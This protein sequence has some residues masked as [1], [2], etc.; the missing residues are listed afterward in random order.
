MQC[1]VI[2]SFLL[3]FTI[4]TFVGLMYRQFSGLPL[5]F[6]VH[7]LRFGDVLNLGCRMIR[8]W[9]WPLWLPVQ[10]FGIFPSSI[11]TDNDTSTPWADELEQ[12]IF[13][14]A[15]GVH[16]TTAFHCKKAPCRM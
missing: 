11:L 3:F 1:R 2:A 9:S 14:S 6:E 16:S 8:Q 7:F 5:G 15:V 13:S 4:Y 10:F 12:K